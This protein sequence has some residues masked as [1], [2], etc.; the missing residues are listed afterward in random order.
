MA[1]APGGLGGAYPVLLLFLL[2][3]GIASYRAFRMTRGVQVSPTRLVAL[4]G[5]W[6]LLF[7]VLVVSDA[8]LE[9]VWAL[10]LE[11]GILGVGFVAAT[12]HVR[13]VVELSEGPGGTL[14]YRLGFLLPAVYLGALAAR[15]VLDLTVLGVNPL[16]AAASGAPATAP[17]G[18]ALA[19]LVLVNGLF[20][21]SAGL[22]IGRS[23]GVLTA[24]RARERGSRTAGPDR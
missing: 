1:A 12:L 9:P 2:I 5:L 6:L 19:A 21:A 13:N 11:F 20:S 16:G 10:P 3:L 14:T 15:L 17:S 23:V 7:L 4:A 22:L 8:T 18:A 24:V